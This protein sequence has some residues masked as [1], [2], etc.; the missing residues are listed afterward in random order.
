MGS[1]IAVWILATLSALLVVVP[2]LGMLGMLNIGGTIIPSSMMGGI[3]GVTL[4]VIW[5]LLMAAVIAAL[6]V[7]AARGARRT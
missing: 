5:M 2:L 3:S 4:A 1:R 6:L 7:I